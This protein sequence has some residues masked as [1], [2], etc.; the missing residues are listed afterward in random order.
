MARPLVA[1]AAASWVLQAM[2]A[3]D[4]AATVERTIVVYYDMLVSYSCCV[5]R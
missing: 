2:Q 1:K 4:R 5:S 3:K